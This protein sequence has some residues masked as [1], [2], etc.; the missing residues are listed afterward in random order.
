MTAL[1]FRGVAEAAL[2]QG[3]ELV[4]RWLPDAKRAG[5]AEVTAANPRR[6]TS[7]GSGGFSINWRTGRWADFAGD[8]KGG[9]LLSLCAYLFH[10]GDQGAACRALAAELGVPAEVA[11]T[12]PAPTR[13]AGAGVDG[14]LVNPV[15]PD[16]PSLELGLRHFRLGQPSRYWR[17]LDQQG[18]LQF[19]V[20]RFDTPDGKQILPLTL[21]RRP[22]GLLAWSWKGLAP[23]R[24]LYRLDELA[25]RP[26][27]TVVVCEGEKAADAAQRLLPEYV[28]TTS[29][30]GAKAA[31]KADWTPLANRRVLL[32]PDH[33][34]AGI[35]YA[36]AVHA[37]LLDA[38][39]AS[40]QALAFT[41]V[42]EQLDRALARR[43]GGAA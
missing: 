34:E 38:G 21:W 14:E 11:G 24:P 35:G 22:S 6:P 41:W 42:A 4:M 36:N 31:D 33:D 7:D 26:Q 28:A 23:P 40:V 27:A 43:K 19:V 29:P 3:F 30:N 8:A 1:D 20:A 17:Y 39:A 13:P 10:N 15:P 16:A 18:R 2:R 32:W 12:K 25:R 37:E 9:D 5:S